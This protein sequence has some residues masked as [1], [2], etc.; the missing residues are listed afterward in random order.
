MRRQRFGTA[1]SRAIGAR[2]SRIERRIDGQRGADR[3]G[4]VARSSV[5]RPWAP[6]TNSRHIAA[7]AGR[8]STTE[9][10]GEN[11][12]ELL[13]TKAR[14]EVAGGPGEIRR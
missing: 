6:A 7:A 4:D 8:A 14:G 1:V 10:A 9:L 2:F 12:P 5:Y 11:L 13:S 3:V